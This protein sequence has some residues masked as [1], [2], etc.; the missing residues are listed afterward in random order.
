MERAVGV[1]DVGMVGSRTS[2]NMTDQAALK[3]Y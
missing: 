2:C 1:A 3:P